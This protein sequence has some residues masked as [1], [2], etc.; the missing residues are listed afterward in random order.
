MS[1][2]SLSDQAR[3]MLPPGG[4]WWFTQDPMFEAFQ[5]DGGLS[6]SWDLRN[7]K[8]EEK[9]MYGLYPSS[10]DR[11]TLMELLLDIPVAYRHAYE[12]LLK[13]VPCKAYVDFEWKGKA[14]LDHSVLKRLVAAIRSKT[15]EVHKHDPKIH[16]CCGTRACV[17]E[18]YADQI[19]HSY[20]IVLEDIIYECNHD[21]QMRTFFTSIPG[22]TWINK[23]GDVKSMI[24]SSVYSRNRAFRL[25]LCTKLSSSCPLVR[26]SGDPLKDDFTVLG[27]LREVEEVLPFFISNPEIGADCV[28]VKHSANTTVQQAGPAATKGQGSKRAR[29]DS[30]SMPVTTEN[31]WPVPI[32]YVQKLLVKL[33]DNATTLGPAVY[34]P[35]E[36][37]WKIQ[38]NH[39][40]RGRKCLVN[41]GKVHDSNQALLFIDRF[42]PGYRVNYQCMTSE[43]RSCPKKILGYISINDQGTDWQ[44]I[45]SCPQAEEI[46]QDTDPSC[47]A[48]NMHDVD[49]ND[50]DDMQDTDPSCD[51]DDM[52]DADPCD[53]DDMRDDHDD[54]QSVSGSDQDMQEPIGVLPTALPEPPFDEDNPDTNTYEMVKARFELKCFQMIKRCKYI[55]V[56]LRHDDVDIITHHEVLNHYCDWTYW[57]PDKNGKLDKLPFAYRW[58]HDFKKKRVENIVVDPTGTENNMYNMWKHFTA[59]E[60]SPINPAEVE[61][62]VKPFIKHFH[63]VITCGNQQHTDWMMDYLGNIVQRPTKKT[64]VAVFLFGQQGC[65]KD[66][67]FD[68]LRLK[69]MGEHCTHQTDNPEDDIFGRF[70]NGLVNRVLL[71]VD[72]VKCMN[73][74]DNRL[75]NLITSTTFRYECKGQMT[76]TLPNMANL[77]FTSNIVDAIPVATDDRRFVLFHCSSVY[78]GKGD[79]FEE[80]GKYLDRP[81]TARAVYQFLMS[82]DLSK[83][84]YSFQD[85]RPVTEYYK[86]AQGMKIPIV[87]RFFSALANGDI[88]ESDRLTGTTQIVKDHCVE[89]NAT[90]LYR[91]YKD[92]HEAGNYKWLQ[93]QNSFSRDVNRIEG[94]K[95][96][97]TNSCIMYLLD[98]SIIKSALISANQYDEDAFIQSSV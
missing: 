16:V 92:Y 39:Q 70:A 54:T 75:K 50:A 27:G 6:L 77:I 32:V 88:P 23:E 98:L 13:I 48:D 89:I 34:L 63:D 44:T 47:D 26:I 81:K 28:F 64:N 30:D 38:G 71:L 24:D 84:P 15:N 73:D 65:G 19:K 94:V 2:L 10:M 80:L 29:V 41:T 95:K 35:A 97:R 7:S 20:H 31:D 5:A 79:Y 33:G 4:R 85:T 49:P 58:L 67:M 25:P 17:E 22:F 53:A 61:E 66:I 37:K 60:L 3:H 78:K 68:F 11:K 14:D 90:L 52:Y 45:P 62:L 43:C 1:E 87:S 69:V 59:S 21:A 72:E 93:T 96:H 42:K 55:K 57:G 46:M 51:T 12:H 36:D 83:Y 74:H 76:I 9:K 91:M 86:E 56:N 18:G 8:G 82:R 40:G